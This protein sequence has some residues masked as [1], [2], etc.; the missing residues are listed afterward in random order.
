[1]PD[2][3]EV[4][5]GEEEEEKL[6]CQR[7]KLFRYDTN[8]KEWKERGVGEM[9]IL[10]HP[11]NGT[12]RL[13]LRREQVHKVVLNQRLD[14]DMKLNPLKT[15]DKAWCW[16]G[17]NHAEDQAGALEELAVRFKNAEQAEEFRSKL[18]ECQKLLVESKDNCSQQ[19]FKFVKID[20]NFLKI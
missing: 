16:G 11:I 10:K 17:I 18:E 14:A 6:F 15:S 2:M 13:L 19:S 4:R 8:S 9:K 5:T 20:L 3:V 12:F 7:A 1:M